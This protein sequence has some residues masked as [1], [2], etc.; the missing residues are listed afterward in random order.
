VPLER[1]FRRR[2]LEGRLS[3]LSP[4]LAVTSTG[5]VLPSSPRATPRTLARGDAWLLGLF[6][7]P[8]GLPLALWLETSGDPAG[9]SRLRAQGL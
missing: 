3:F 7:N 1:D 2:A 8:Q 6:D 5:S 9:R 4:A